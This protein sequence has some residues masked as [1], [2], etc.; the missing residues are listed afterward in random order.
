MK[1][2]IKDQN[3]C[4]E[5]IDELAETKLKV[6]K[7][8]G[9]KEKLLANL[10]TA[11]D[12]K[13]KRIA[14][15][16]SAEEETEK[17]AAEILIL[18]SILEGNIEN[19]KRA[20]ELLVVK[21]ELYIE[22]QLLEKTLRS[23]GDAVISTDRN[24]NIVFLNRVAESLTGWTMD[25]AFGKSIYDVFN[26]VD[27]F[28]KKKAEDIVKEVFVS[29]EIQILSNYVLLITKNK[30]EILIED[31]AAPILDENN[32][33]VGVVIIFRDYTDKSEK[34]KE[35][36]YISLHDELTGVFNRRFYEAELERIDTERNLPISLIM[37]DINGLKLIND[38]FGHKIGDELLVKATNAIKQGCRS[39]DLIARI[40]GDE[41]IV[42]MPSTDDKE[43]KRVIHRIQKE[44][45]LQSIK[46]LDIS[47]SFGSCT[48]TDS[49][50]DIKDL[51]ELAENRMYKRK[52]Y[53][54]LSMR[55]RTIGLISNTLFAKSHRELIHSKKVSAFCEIFARILGFNENE[56]KKNGLAGLM[57]DI[58]KI[59]IDD[60]ILN[61]TGKLN[62]Q[63][64]IE[65]KKHPEIGYKI[66]G[67][68]NEFA[69]VSEYVLEHHEKW[70]GSGYPQ[71][72]S[73]NQIKI[74][75]RI[76]SIVD[77]FAAMTNERSYGRSMS[78]EKALV[79]I[80]RASG[81]Q[82]DPTL[83]KIFTQNFELFE[84]I[85]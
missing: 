29:H 45:K 40:G 82:F 48:K 5:I 78:N 15:L 61:K 20:A 84:P 81:T 38:S 46:G 74:E 54:G 9:E 51:F 71:G 8:M 62:N 30:E 73:G 31:S 55:N 42:L 44:S 16:L 6:L 47:I 1:K 11:K 27:Q 43:V 19:E 56:I 77:S 60:S 33:I 64:Y 80:A 83:V 53:E 21:N 59:G 39:D 28:T 72:L 23:I 18:E 36:E 58:G 76:I 63:E 37:G 66:L 22:K 4:E 24:S 35:I 65:I 75:S 7:Q 67:S 12:E 79:E 49:T 2:E 70:D 26:I 10:A 25:E 3:E 13:S 34:I 57:H 52:L 68:V 41:F 14:Q 69:E 85:A 17:Q 50:Q 32:A